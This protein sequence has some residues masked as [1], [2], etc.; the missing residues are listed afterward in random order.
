VRRRRL[1][2]LLLLLLSI[3]MVLQSQPLVGAPNV[4]GARDC[5]DAEDLVWRCVACA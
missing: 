5:V 2:L 1:L 3:R 4:I